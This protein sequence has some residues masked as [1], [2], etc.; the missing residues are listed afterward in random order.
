MFYK[1]DVTNGIPDTSRL[2]IGLE[3]LK[4]VGMR[5]VILEIDLGDGKYDF[6]KFSI[7]KMCNLLLKLVAWC[8]DNLHK[9]S[10]V[11][12]NFRDMP[13]AMSSDPERVFRVVEFL[14]KLPP[15]L[16]LFGLL[17]EDPGGQC[18]P[19]EFSTWARFVRTIMDAN[20][21]NG[22]LLVHVHEQ[23]CLG[24]VTVLEVCVSV[25]SLLCYL[26]QS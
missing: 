25:H 14:A 1:T 22:H 5:N 11:L 17:Y 21:W 2:P 16:R 6:K 7:D 9:N 19:E 12:V 13:N 8:H 26:S 24:D 4:R 10:R 18:M 3:K 20:K 23:F 15:R